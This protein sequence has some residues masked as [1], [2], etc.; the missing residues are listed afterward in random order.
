M[1]SG[2][3]LGLGRASSLAACPRNRRIQTCQ[4]RFVPVHSLPISF[5]VQ[6]PLYAKYQRSNSGKNKRRKRVR[7][8]RRRRRRSAGSSSRNKNKNKNQEQQQ[9][10][11]QHHNQQNASTLLAISAPPA[12]SLHHAS[13]RTL[14]LAQHAGDG[15]G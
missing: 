9:Q 6:D 8:K 11:Q 12:S 14:L 4:I 7:R 1:S 15:G 3:P 13:L 10:Q 5:A 2:M